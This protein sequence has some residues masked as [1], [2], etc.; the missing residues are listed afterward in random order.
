MKAEVSDFDD[1]EAPLAPAHEVADGLT[2]EG[3]NSEHRV[4]ADYELVSLDDVRVTKL[5]QKT[6]LG[7]EP[8]ASRIV[9]AAVGS[10]RF[11]DTPALA[12]LRPGVVDVEIRAPAQVL[13]HAIARSRRF[14]GSKR[15]PVR[16]AAHPCAAVAAAA[17]NCGFIVS[18]WCKR[19][20]RE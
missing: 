10:E 3:L 1:R 19:Y 4:G 13:D 9:P 11:D 18:A 16:G 15:P 2:L 17:A 20:R 6:S 7:A 8:S 5:Q 14:A 12:L